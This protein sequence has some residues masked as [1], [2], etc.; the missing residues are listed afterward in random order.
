MPKPIRIPGIMPAIN[1]LLTESP[2]SVAAI[3]MGS[4]GGIIGHMQLEAAVT[5]TEKS[6]S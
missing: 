3:I 2:V 6:G 4:D 1:I 5:P